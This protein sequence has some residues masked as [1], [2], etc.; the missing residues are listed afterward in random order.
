MDA[1]TEMTLVGRA[2]AAEVH[3]ETGGLSE[4]DGCLFKALHESPTARIKISEHLDG[5][6]CQSLQLKGI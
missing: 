2:I 5:E 3:I 1:V 4:A 6:I